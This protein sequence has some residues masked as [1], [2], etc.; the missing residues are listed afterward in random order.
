M[1]IHTLFKDKLAKAASP[2]KYSM[3]INNRSWS[4]SGNSPLVPPKWRDPFGMV[5][6]A[7]ELGFAGTLGM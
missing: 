6:H 4:W 2:W 1:A 5:A 7:T 3:P